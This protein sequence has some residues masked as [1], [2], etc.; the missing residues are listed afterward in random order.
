MPIGKKLVVVIP[1]YNEEEMLPVTIPAM[2]EVL[3]RMVSAGKI[4]S[5]SKLLFV[6]DGSTDKTWPLIEQYRQINAF[7]SGISF[8][9]NYGHQNA[10][11][12]GLKVS[13]DAD[14]VITID[15]DLQDDINAMEE[16]LDRYLEGYDVV[17]GVRNSRETDTF[18]K[19]NSAL[20]FYKLMDKMGTKTIQNHA[21]FRLM[22]RRSVDA[23]LEY[24]E[25]N[26]FLR[27]IVPQVGFKSINVYYARNERQSGTSK[28]PLGKMIKF[29]LDGI[30]S[31]STTP[32]RMIV[33]LGVA[34][35]AISVILI[36]NTFIQHLH[37]NTSKGWPSL[38][39][40]IWFLGGS[41]LISAGILGEYLGKVFF[42]VKQRPRFNIAEDSYT[43]K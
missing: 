37:G 6:D 16:M 2:S 31:F 13:K 38:M 32:L 27:G 23:L 19:R 12:A 20:F 39:I 17:Y 42:E 8:S 41:Q 40:S 3:D 22:S 7:V 28:Y 35:L 26:V 33:W 11:L 43:D 36:V 10:L 34:T 18:F 5:S 24:P 29:A 9:K 1:A 25:R 15:A 4:S 14:V 30:T 21:D